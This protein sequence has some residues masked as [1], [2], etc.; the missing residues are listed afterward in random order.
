MFICKRV[1]PGRDV[2]ARGGVK[3]NNCKQIVNNKS[4]LCCI[5]NFIES[6]YSVQ[7]L[8]DTNVF[9]KNLIYLGYK[10]QI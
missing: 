9:N 3:E 2:K 8:K 4:I 1:C 10:W 6:M 7:Q 5:V